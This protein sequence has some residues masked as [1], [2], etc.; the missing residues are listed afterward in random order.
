MIK[1][2]YLIGA[3]CFMPY[4]VKIL[5]V[6]EGLKGWRFLGGFVGCSWIVALWPALVVILLVA[7]RHE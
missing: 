2:L 3:L 1:A 4:Y 7:R 6:D 5:I